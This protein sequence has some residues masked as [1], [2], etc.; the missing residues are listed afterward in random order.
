MKM[1]IIKTLAII[2]LVF[3]AACILIFKM[4]SVMWF[5]YITLLVSAFFWEK[6][7]ISTPIFLAAALPVVEFIW[8]GI[9]SKFDVEKFLRDL[10]SS[11]GFFDV[12]KFLRDLNSSSGFFDYGGFPG[13]AMWIFI[14]PFAVYKLS[15]IWGKE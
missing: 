3:Y 10:N 1:K 11:S 4:G 2:M 13:Y 8:I 14:I 6:Q 9:Y 5:L 15:Y 7:S 12:E